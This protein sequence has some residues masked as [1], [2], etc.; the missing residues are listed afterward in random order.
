MLAAGT[1]G[2]GMCDVLV[3]GPSPRRG[4]P[5]SCAQLQRGQMSLN[6]QLCDPV[7]LIDNCVLTLQGVASV[8][9]VCHIAA[10]LPPTLTLDS[11]RVSQVSTGVLPRVRMAHRP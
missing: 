9:I 10:S 5:R 4:V 8:P 2:G 11:L 3:S 7:Q 1:A 6:P